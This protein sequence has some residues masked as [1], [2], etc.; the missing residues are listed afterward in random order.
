MIWWRGKGLWMGLIVA[1]II[2]AS[3][4]GPGAE[5]TGLL[6]SALTVFMLRSWAGEESSLYSFPVRF[7]PPVLLLFAVLA[8]M[9]H[10]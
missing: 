6:V 5:A 2:I 10:R 3:S 8:F 9:G 7:W 4:K 1:L